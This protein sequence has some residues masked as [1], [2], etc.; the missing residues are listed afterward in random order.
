MRA[1]GGRIENDASLGDRVPSL[2]AGILYKGVFIGL[3]L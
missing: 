3:V 1:K 2:E